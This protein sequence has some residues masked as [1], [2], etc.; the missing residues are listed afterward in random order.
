M[1]KA[2]LRKR[3]GQAPRI[4]GHP[5]SIVYHCSVTSRQTYLIAALIFLCFL[6][7]SL[8]RMDVFALDE[9]NSHYPNALNFN[10]NGFNARFPALFRH[11]YAAAVSYRSLRSWSL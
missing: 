2:S 9:T 5:N 10:E 4:I 7:I 1:P 6:A 3:P 8:A 11:E